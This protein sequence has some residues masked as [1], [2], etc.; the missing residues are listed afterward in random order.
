M[1][2]N[3]N[4]TQPIKNNNEDYDSYSSEDENLKTAGK[5]MNSSVTMIN[6]KVINN[7][8]RASAP[9]NSKAQ[10]RNKSITDKLYMPF[11]TDKSFKIDVNNKLTRIKEDS[12]NNAIFNHKLIKK[13]DEVEKIG[14][15]LFIYNNPS[16]FKSLINLKFRYQYK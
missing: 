1:S 5:K 14:K 3:N 11:I 6:S 12:K 10:Q 15:Q 9:L 16:N 8:N 7:K 4:L 13:K 2:K